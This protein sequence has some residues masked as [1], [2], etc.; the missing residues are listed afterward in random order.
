MKCK[1]TSAVIATAI[2]VCS[3]IVQAATGTYTAWFDAGIG[4][5]TA[6]TTLGSAWSGTG[7]TPGAA[8]LA[9]NNWE[10][11]V[12]YTAADASAD[13]VKETITIASE[14]MDFDDLPA[15]TDDLFSSAKYAITIA[16]NTSGE[17]VYAAL[18][19]VNGDPAWVELDGETPSTDAPNTVTVV[20]NKKTNTV[21]FASISDTEYD[22]LPESGSALT[23]TSFYGTGTLTLLSGEKAPTVH[24]VTLPALSGLVVESV[25]ADGT[26]LTANA[27]GSYTVEDG[28][29]VVFTFAAATGYTI[30]DPETK[31]VTLEKVTADT[32][33]ESSALPTATTSYSLVPSA[34]YSAAF[35]A[36]LTAAW[37]D[38]GGTAV[39]PNKECSSA[40]FDD[41]A[42]TIT[43]A[44]N[45]IPVN[46]DVF[47]SSLL[48]SG[49]WTM[50]ID[51]KLADVENGAIYG[52]GGATWRSQTGWILAK[53]SG[54]TVS[55]WQYSGSNGGT[56]EALV[57]SAEINTMT[58]E[59]HTYTFTY[60]S[61][62]M[63]LTLYVDGA[64]SG[65]A[66]TFTSAML[67]GYTDSQSAIQFGR[68]W[69]GT[70]STGTVVGNGFELKNF[71]TW[72]QALD[73]D[74]IKAIANGKIASMSSPYE[75]Q[76][77]S[78][79]GNS[80]SPSVTGWFSSWSGDT[81]KTGYQ[82]IGPDG[83]PAALTQHLSNNSC[84]PYVGASGL[85]SFTASIYANVSAIAAVAGSK[86]TILHLGSYNG[87]QLILAKNGESVELYYGTSSS[88]VVS[89]GYAVS[90]PEGYNLWTVV[91]D[92]A[93]CRL[94]L[95]GVEQYTAGT[96]AT[97]DEGALANGLQIGSIYGGN[98]SGF[99][100]SGDMAV[101]AFRVDNAALH[102]IV[103]AELAEMYPAFT[104]AISVTNSLAANPATRFLIAQDVS[105]TAAGALP[106]NAVVA[107]G[108]K[109]TLEAGASLG[110]LTAGADGAVLVGT[111]VAGSYTLASGGLLAEAGEEGTLS[112]AKGATL[113]L[114]LNENKVAGGYTADGVTLAKGASVTMHSEDKGYTIT[115]DGPYTAPSS[116]AQGARWTGAT[117]ATYATAGNWTDSTVPQAG[118]N[119]VFQVSADHDTVEI[120]G[121]EMGQKLNMVAIYST[122]GTTATFDYTEAYKNDPTGRTALKCETLV[123]KTP[124][125]NN[126]AL[127]VTGTTIVYN[128]AKI[129][130][131]FGA[132][133]NTEESASTVSYASATAGVVGGDVDVTTVKDIWLYY[134]SVTDMGTLTLK[135]GT[136]D[137]ENARYTMKSV[138]GWTNVVVEAGVTLYLTNVTAAVD[139]GVHI[140]K[141]EGAT[142]TLP[143]HVRIGTDGYLEF[144]TASVGGIEYET[145]EEAIAAGSSPSDVTVFDKG[146]AIPSGY[147]LVEATEGE[148][149]RLT[150]RS[151][152]TAATF[153]L[154]VAGAGQVYESDTL[155]TID[156]NTK[157]VFTE[158]DAFEI[159]HKVGET[160]YD[161]SGAFKTV[162][163]A[164]EI[165][166]A[167]DPD[168]AVTV[169]GETVKVEPEV[170]EV[171]VDE[172]T[173]E[174]MSMTESGVVFG[175]KTI[176]GLYYAVL[177]GETPDFT[178]TVPDYVQASACATKLT[179][180]AEFD[181]RVRYFRIAVAAGSGK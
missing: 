174:P 113:D 126:G 169:G 123:L 51:A 13:F 90:A 181:G 49:D 92:G 172:K 48:G 95:N 54:N 64:V 100:Y 179:A 105:V 97:I 142:V 11:S 10:K 31:T 152:A 107:S 165:S 50:T 160:T 21:T 14:A 6:E 131:S 53:N 81:F 134:A 137:E 135:N 151:T 148:T 45:G 128:G 124:L 170:A 37:S 4:S 121:A 72:H 150:L 79:F 153:V 122:D 19:K 94:Y 39:N 35:T 36:N 77:W 167:L 102:G 73:D 136:S 114:T 62:E 28:A 162:I 76:T 60:D 111:G 27:D 1:V 85:S 26:A 12:V 140:D 144:C 125:V 88:D 149:T 74:A 82:T 139:G 40:T 115:V 106:T 63:T 178:D 2:A 154:D 133:H 17:T 68:A 104:G 65:T 132:D 43:S 87:K 42:M 120:G 99:T 159:A 147:A 173:V 5:F 56:K 8:S 129:S 61:T 141:A 146:T 29:T 127:Q 116:V 9:I 112:I 103:V 44:G 155:F 47:V 93:S 91:K 180:A 67:S 157:S 38:V 34:T 66:K 30:A 145:V 46:E 138:A 98:I 171:T 59:F 156:A 108:V 110:A 32:A 164:D 166:F 78:G 101:E 7:A 143:E 119:A 55:L 18:V 175:V 15:P 158:G 16:N 161:I 96:T 168:G 58:S 84:Q 57:T 109:V 20:Y 70:A 24:S 80:A 176:P 89:L 23:K 25:T 69:G 3:F 33:V 41:G 71:A 22:A 52:F 177:S 118:S 75:Y 86:N 83:Q 163:T 130:S 117:D